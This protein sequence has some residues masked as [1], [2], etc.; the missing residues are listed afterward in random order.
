MTRLHP[1]ELPPPEIIEAAGKV[2][3]WFAER[4]ITEWML[5][6]IEKRRDEPMDRSDMCRYDGV[7]VEPPEDRSQ[8]PRCPVCWTN[9]HMHR[10][11]CRYRNDGMAHHVRPA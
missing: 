9:G 8:Y 5:D 6:G 11:D 2:A 4:G 7:A 3:D 1:N 10:K